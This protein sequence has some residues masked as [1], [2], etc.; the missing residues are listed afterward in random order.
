MKKLIGVLCLV[1][2]VFSFPV[3]ASAVV[4]DADGLQAVPKPPEPPPPPDP[5]P[6]QP[7]P[8][9]IDTGDP[10]PYAPPAMR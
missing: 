7:R 10:P 8:G 3:I 1:G 4:P 2:L 9:P 6:P 5:R